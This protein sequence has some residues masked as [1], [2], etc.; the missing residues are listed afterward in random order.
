VPFKGMVDGGGSVKFSV[1][2]KHGKATRAGLFTLRH[3]PVTCDQGPG[4]VGYAT[5]NVVNVK[6]RKFSYRFSF[7]VGN[8]NIKGKISRNGKEA[9]GSTKYGP[10]DPDSEHTN[11]ISDTLSWKAA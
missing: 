7:S 5:Q 10:A 1:E 6:Q 2:F 4:A 9:S 8:A 3:I 11:C